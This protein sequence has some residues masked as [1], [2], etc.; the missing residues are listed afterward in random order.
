VGLI[1]RVTSN[2]PSQ[3]LLAWDEQVVDNVCRWLDCGATE[4]VGQGPAGSRGLPGCAFIDTIP[5]CGFALVQS[6]TFRLSIVRHELKLEL[7]TAISGLRK[8]QTNWR[9][10]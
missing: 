5:G 4:D 2:F 1:S 6:S 7:Y 8:F 10:K 9:K 3:L